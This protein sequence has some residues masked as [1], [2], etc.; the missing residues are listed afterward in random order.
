MKIERELL[1]GAA[2]IAV[3]QSLSREA[4]YGYELGQEIEKKCRGI[5]CFGHG[6]L[7]PLLYNLEAHGY[8]STEWRQAGNGRERRYYTIT[9]KG[10]KHL[11]EQ[12][13]QWEE[14]DAAMKLILEFGVCGAAST[15]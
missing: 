5:L 15:R 7:Y 8:V 2:P 13:M 1:K 12:R 6:T 9:E 10:V 14:L 11:S 4:M 3:L